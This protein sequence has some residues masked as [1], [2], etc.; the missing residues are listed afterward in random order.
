MLKKSYASKE[1]IPAGAEGFYKELEDGTCVL[2]LEDMK[3]EEDVEKLSKA[4]QAERDA[5]KQSKGMFKT[6]EERIIELDSKLKVKDTQGEQQQQ[7]PK[8]ASDVDLL[9]IQAKMKEQ[10]KQI[11]AIQAERDA[12]AQEQ[13]R[14]TILKALRKVSDGKISNEAFQDL[15]LYAS[16]LDITEDGAVVTK[17][18]GRAIDDW[19]G[20]TLKSRP[21]WLAK[22]TPGGANGGSLQPNTLSQNAIKLNKLLEKDELTPRESL[23]AQE[24]ALLVKNEE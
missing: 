22:N 24:L 19:F 7:Q 10:A 2:Q 8:K 12:L 20:E 11:A 5:H 3:T 16:K 18:E 9:A 13:K 17:D 21:H 6:L 4:L 14:N 23:E 15:E 1:E